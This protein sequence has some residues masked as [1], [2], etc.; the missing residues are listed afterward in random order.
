[1][2]AVQYLLY[3]TVIVETIDDAIRIAREEKRFPRLVT[4]DGEV[5][6]PSGAVTG[7]RTQHESHGLLGRSSEIEELEKSV[8]NYERNIS[9][10][11]SRMQTLTSQSQKIAD[12]LTVLEQEANTVRQSISEIGIVCA[13]NS[14]EVDN[15]SAAIEALSK[16]YEMLQ[17]QG[18]ALEDKLAS[19]QSR[20]GGMADDDETLQQKLQAASDAAAKEREATAALSAQVSDLRVKQAESMHALEELRRGLERAGRARSEMVE[21]AEKQQQLAVE[22]EARAVAFE[23]QVKEAVHQSH[24]LSTSHAA[25]HKTVLEAQKEQQYIIE[26]IDQLTKLLKESREKCAVTQ[27]EVH[28]L[29]LDCSQKEDRIQF[30]QERIASEY[31]LALASLSEEEVGVDEHD[32]TEREALIH[33]YRDSLQKLGNVNLAAIEEYDELEKRAAFLKAQNDD[34]VK[35]RDTLLNVVKRIDATTQ[36]M[37]MQTFNQISEN[38]KNYF[39]RL[40]NGGQARL[41]LLDENNPLECGI[42]IEARPP[43]KKPQSISL[44]SGGEQAMTAIALLFS[45]FAAKPSPFCVLDEVDAP[46]DDA[47]IGR[48]LMMVNEFTEKSQFIM[49]T[50]NKQTMA[51]AAAIYGVTQQEAG[52]SQLVSVRLEEAE[53]VV[54]ASN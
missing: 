20:I 41:F 1:M 42:E 18:T 32:E 5:V 30:F 43:G 39:R 48:F 2:P 13:R 11:V 45:I 3:N 21:Q 4:L 36:D 44:L 25:T 29:E 7:G 10:A 49:I 47:N 26:S 23:E 40:F 8:S 27:R 34:L 31:G 12:S 28:R 51:H 15:L 33:K 14:A 24:E 54:A 16:R 19:A 53:K 50:H 52:I 6:T 38:F 22:M 37:F 46:L 9:K 17:T 35:A